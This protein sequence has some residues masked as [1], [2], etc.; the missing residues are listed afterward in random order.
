MTQTRNL[1]SRVQ[2]ARERDEAQR[3]EREAIVRAET[4]EQQLRAATQRLDVA[5][6]E[7][8]FLRSVVEMQEGM[9]AN[10]QAEK[11]A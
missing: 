3:R 8:A 10:L 7:L 4:A 1:Q 6:R 11:A 2:A 5:D 9:I